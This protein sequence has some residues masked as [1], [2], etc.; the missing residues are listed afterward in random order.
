MKFNIL[1]AL[2]NDSDYTAYMEEIIIKESVPNIIYQLKK[3]KQK[4][5]KL[6]NTEN[7]NIDHAFVL[8]K[9]NE[10]NNSSNKI[11]RSKNIVDES[12]SQ[13]QKEKQLEAMKQLVKEKMKSL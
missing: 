8:D 4:V 5:K 12:K 6:Y 13:N 2:D 10:E 1:V 9:Q 7:K 3:E 11:Q